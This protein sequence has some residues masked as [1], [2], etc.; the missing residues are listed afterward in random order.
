[1]LEF[2][3]MSQFHVNERNRI[4][5][6]FLCEWRALS[7]QLHSIPA[8]NG[9]ESNSSGEKEEEDT[10]TSRG[11]DLRS[12]CQ[13]QYRVT[14]FFWASCPNATWNTILPMGSQRFPLLSAVFRRSALALTA[15][16]A[17]DFLAGRTTPRFFTLPLLFPP[18]SKERVRWF[19]PWQ[20]WQSL[21]KWS[22]ATSNA[23]KWEYVQKG[24]MFPVGA[25]PQC[26]D[27]FPIIRRCCASQLI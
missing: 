3:R 20:N 9:G 18:L 25:Q 8:V 10:L 16:G 24:C 5:K 7:T 22:G 17:I 13:G 1:M 21:I 12:Y 26:W 19:T 27:S 15:F 14:E 2:V 11:M 6:G 4:R 23:R